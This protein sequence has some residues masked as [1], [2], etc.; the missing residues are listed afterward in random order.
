MPRLQNQE[1]DD[2]TNEE[3]RHFDPAK[4]IHVELKDL[5]FDLMESPFRTG[6]EYEADLAS[7][8]AKAKAAGVNCQEGKQSALGGKRRKTLKES[9]PWL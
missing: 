9:D 5:G 4:R 6:D 1:A 8:R 3:F 2:L 7:A